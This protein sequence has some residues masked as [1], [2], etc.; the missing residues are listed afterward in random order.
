MVRTYFCP[1]CGAAMTFDPTSQKLVCSH[2]GGSMTNEEAERMTLEKE[3]VE[4]ASG[5][6]FSDG[7]D[8]SSSE[9][10]DS[11]ERL[12]FKVYNCTTC[13]AEILTD[14]Y[15]TATM[16][17]YCGNPALMEDRIEGILRPSYVIPFSIDK[18]KAVD[19]FKK[20]TGKGLLTPSGFKS[21]NTLEKMTGMY[22]PYWMY[23][24]SVHVDMNARC[25]RTSRSV[26][27]NY[28]YIQ[29]HNYSVMRGADGQY[30]KV[31]ADAS[32]KLDDDMMDLLE[33]FNYGDM[34]EFQEHYM[35]GYQAERYNFK[36][37][38]IV[39]RAIRRVSGYA[40]SDVR[41][42]ITG[43]GTVNVLSKNV[44]ARMTDAKYAMLPIWM[45]NYRYQGKDYMTVINGQT[46]KLVGKLPISKG[47]TV[48]SFF[49]SVVLV[50]IIMSIISLI[51]G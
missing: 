3:A 1:S 50:F 33:P 15:T 38:G 23:D 45:L 34:I 16:C 42:S 37:E 44:N 27:G 48:I 7:T 22:V 13:G 39:D 10:E 41:Q 51:L 9:A 24:V 26:R 12:D 11:E 46:G 40:E 36:A 25:T 21:R 28:E 20:W 8:E 19:I 5:T 32:E 30:E 31:P 35:Q 4:N 17:S 14:K 29:T 2:C 18:D 6:E 49:V 43:Y 47:K